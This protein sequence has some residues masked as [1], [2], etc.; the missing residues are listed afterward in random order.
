VLPKTT[1]TRTAV[2]R[3]ICFAT[4]GLLSVLAGAQAFAEPVAIGRSSL[5]LPDAENWKVQDLES[6]NLGYSGDA[7]GAMTMG[8]KQL[9]YSAA[10]ALVKAVFVTKVTKGGVA[11]LTMTWN[12]PCPAV[13]ASSNVFKAD[14]GNLANVDCLVVIKVSQFDS[15]LNSIPQLNKSFAAARPNTRDGFYIEYSKSMGA[16]GFA[17]SQALVANDFKGTEGDAVKTETSI[18]PSV[19]I[20][21]MAFA[22]SNASAIDSLSG[23]WSIPAL[24]FNPK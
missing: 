16:G 13:R 3:N 14:K 7:N 21:A 10:D 1:L 4:F 8:A 19:L 11:G 24:V 20:W 12:N 6:A 5:T 17:F 18:S 2:Y 22:K 9:T 15:F 23:K